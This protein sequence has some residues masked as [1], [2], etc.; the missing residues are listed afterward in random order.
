M[1]LGY[2][3]TKNSWSFKTWSIFL[4]DLEDGRNKFIYMS[5]QVWILP[6]KVSLLPLYVSWPFL[7]K[8]FKELQNL[9]NLLV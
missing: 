3:F 8:K 4:C 7:Y 5:A 9:V 1:D 2:L 6:A